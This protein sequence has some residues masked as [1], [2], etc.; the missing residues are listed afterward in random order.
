MVDNGAGRTFV[1]GRD[2]NRRNGRTRN[3]KPMVIRVAVTICVA[4]G[5]IA[6]PYVCGIRLNTRFLVV[7]NTMK[8]FL[9]FS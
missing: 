1:M 8:T 9:L 4:L 7:D 5:E 2:H 3:N 6:R